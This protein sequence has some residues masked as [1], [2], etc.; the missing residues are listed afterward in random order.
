MVNI[1]CF[2]RGIIARVKTGKTEFVGLLTA[3]ANSQPDRLKPSASQGY[4]EKSF[5]FPVIQDRYADCQLV[6]LLDLQS[7]EEGSLMGLRLI[8]NAKDE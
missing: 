7:F 8:G 1:G 5:A 3:I 4:P 2:Q 6:I